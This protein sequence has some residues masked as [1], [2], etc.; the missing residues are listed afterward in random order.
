MSMF[1]TMRTLDDVVNCVKGYQTQFL[2]VISAIIFVIGGFYGYF[3]YKQAREESAYHA[4]VAVVKYVDAPVKKEAVDQSKE[5]D[6]SFLNKEEFKSFEE[7]W[8]K[9]EEECKENYK[10]H[11]SSG[12]ASFFLVYRVQALIELK[13]LQEAIDVMRVAISKMR[14]D[15]VKNH[16]QIK[17]ALMLID[18]KDESSCNEGIELLRKIANAKDSVAQDS[19][20]YHLGEYYWYQRRFNEARNY[21]N[22]L[23]LAFD[24]Q[25]EYASPWVAV[26]KEKLRLIDS[27]VE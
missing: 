16:Y 20:L 11:K 27:D 24:K 9:I 4:L 5:E 25:E 22:Q 21:W 3:Y 12:I 19:A 26:A 2:V 23:L 14:N 18:S 13:K 6:L 10:V 17:L 1:R 7:K 8:T 15:N